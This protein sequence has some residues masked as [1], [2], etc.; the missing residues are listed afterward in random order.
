MTIRI[1]TLLLGSVPV[2]SGI[3]G[4]VRGFADLDGTEV[5]V[6]AKRLPDQEIMGEIYCALLCQAVGLPA[7]EPLV[8]QDQADGSWMFASVDFPHPNC[9][10]FLNLDVSDPRAVMIMAEFLDRWPSLPKAV[11]FDEWIQNKDRN[12]GNILWNDEN[13]FA[14]ID[15]GKALG[16]DPNYPDGN[17]LV[18][19]WLTK[20]ASDENAQRRMKK[21]AITFA[22][23]FDDMQADQCVELIGSTLASVMPRS[24]A[25]FVCERRPHL[26]SLI[27]DRFPSSQIRML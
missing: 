11:A 13:E 4:A 7:P 26:D 20:A 6:V 14:L 17:K 18:V 25:R 8:L 16:I 2:G 23:T 21:A 19:I 24:F 22:N 1:G 15:H 12:P 5:P 3:N 27:I 10:Q 9:S